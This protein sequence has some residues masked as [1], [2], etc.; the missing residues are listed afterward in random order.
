MKWFK[1]DANANTDAKLRKVRLKYGMEGYGLYW[2][3][4][5]L[6]AANVEK[7]NL[8][9]ELEH[10]AEIIAHDTGIHFERVEEMMR[11]MVNLH[12]FEESTGRITCLKMATRTDEYTQKLIRDTAPVPTSSRQTPDTVTTKSLLIEEKRREENRKEEKK[13]VASAPR[14]TAPTV[15]DVA[16]YSEQSGHL[17]DPSQFVDFYESKG[18]L[19]GKSKMKDWKAAVRTWANRET[20]NQSKNSSRQNSLHHDLT[21]KSWAG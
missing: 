15:D 5:E 11:H 8:S 3:C 10:D 13:K 18:W 16:W 17:I 4:L 19:V 20:V 7:H 6:I 9:F 2:Y 1:H 21:D 12:L 14:F